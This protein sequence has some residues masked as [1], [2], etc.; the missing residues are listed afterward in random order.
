MDAN[1]REWVCRAGTL[2]GSFAETIVVDERP[3]GN[4]E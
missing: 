4:H 2:P 1:V 3:A